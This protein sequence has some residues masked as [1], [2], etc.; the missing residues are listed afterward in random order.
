MA[1]VSASHSAGEQRRILV[2]GAFGF[3][4]RWLL[5]DLLDR[6]PA[7]EIIACHKRGEGAGVA[8]A[9]VRAVAL[10]LTDRDAVFA[11]VR[12]ARPTC[13]IH[14]AAISV[15]REASLDPRRAWDVNL[16]GTMYLAD[17][18]LAHAADARFIQISSSEVYGGSFEG[19]VG[20]L[21]ERAALAPLNMYAVTKAAADLLVGKQVH[22]GL[23]AIRF[24][25]FNHSGPGQSDAFVVSSLASQIAKIEQGLAPAT[26][27]VGNT[28]VSRDILDV[29]DVVRA[30]ASAAFLPAG[31]GA[32]L[33]NLASGQ[34]YAIGDIA[35]RLRSMAGVRIA[36]EI[37]PQRVRPNDLKRTLGNSAHAEAVL[38]WRPSIGLD[39]TLSDVLDYW[40]GR[41]GAART[42]TER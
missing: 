16:F 2:T 41:V 17:A 36:V 12:N 20:G 19:A 31:H 5:A 29:R 40:R 9:R 38:G 26:L 32:D 21:D 23:D 14:L 3:V 24:R 6:D 39:Q 4:G 34:S 8:D 27:Y 25:P 35:D 33:F 37:D 7:V 28:D 13:V 42:G 10:D 15:P 22:D 11:A 1:V 18:V 30:Y